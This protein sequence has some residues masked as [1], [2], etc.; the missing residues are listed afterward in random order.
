MD[1]KRF[2]EYEVGVQKVRMSGVQG[3]GLCPVHDDKKPSF[4]FNVE[5]G[6]NYC[7]SCGYKGNA[8]TLAKMLN[9]DNPGQ[10]INSFTTLLKQLHI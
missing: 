10:Y 5:T 9:M 4:S 7:H 1:Y 8:Y 2:Y 6:Q 3:I